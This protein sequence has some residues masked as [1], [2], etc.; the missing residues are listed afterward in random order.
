M[1]GIYGYTGKKINEVN[2]LINFSVHRG[3]DGH[4]IWS[5]DYITLGQN[6]LAITDTPSVS[7]QPW[8][9][10]RGNVL[11]YNGEIFNYKDLCRRYS[12]QFT[13]KTNCDTE[14]L[15]WLLENKSLEEINNELLDS[16]HAFVFYNKEKKQVILSRD[17]AGIKPLYFSETNQNLIFSSEIK[18]LKNIIPGSENINLKSL[19]CMAYCGM[20]FFRETMFQ[21]VMKV[22]AGETLIYDLEDK[23][24]KISFR[25]IVT[26]KS[27][28]KFEIEEFRQEIDIMITNST[29]GIRKFGVFLSGGL[30]STLIAYKLNQ[31]FPEIET[32]TNYFAPNVIDTKADYNE[33]FLIAQKFCNE[34]RINNNPVEITPDIISNNW[35]DS[36]HYMEEPRYNL[37]M[38][39]YFYTNQ[40]LSKNKTV[41]TMSGDMGDELLGGYEKYYDFKNNPKQPKSWEELIYL[42][43]RRFKRPITLNLKFN[44]NELH[45]LLCKELPSQIWNPDDPL[46]SLM[47][48]D[49]ITCVTEDFFSRNDKYGMAASMEGRFPFASKRFMNYALDIHSSEKIGNT[50]T[51]LKLPIKKSSR[52]FLP[53]YIINKKKTGWSLPITNW[54]ESDQNLKQTYLNTIKQN[55]CLE[56]II[57]SENYNFGKTSVI[58]WMMRSWAQNFDL[59]INI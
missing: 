55:D 42:W 39:M 57:S 37:N 41:V 53:D 13:P 17:H 49:C 36:I 46:N 1:C 8:V 6:L 20:N 18:G 47:A 34:N 15:I 35:D 30:D 11:V 27:S 10:Q 32:Y 54:I 4:D 50:K 28:K 23:K 7:N 3:P 58:S 12:N 38:P 40:F 56:N 31:I 48:L 33:D 21:G 52:T 26:P 16:M 25:N 14:L 43:M 45:E 9:S 24:F 5:D 59:N 22:N 19:V 29:L 51:D 2:S 44:F